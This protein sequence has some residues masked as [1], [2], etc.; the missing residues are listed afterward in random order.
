MPKSRRNKSRTTR[1]TRKLLRGWPLPQHAADESKEGRGRV[2]VIG[3]E[4]TLPGAVV[5]A[6]IAA[7]RAGAGK[8]QIATCRS[9]APHVGI[10]V[11]ECLAFGLDETP[12]GLISPDAV[13]SLS[14]FMNETD[15]VLIGPGMKGHSDEKHFVRNLLK[16][17]NG[18]ATLVID[19]GALDPRN[20]FHGDAILT[21]H[22][23]EMSKM[24]RLPLQEVVKHPEETSIEAARFFN[25]V[26]ALKGSVT[27]IASPKGELFRYDSGD[28]GLATSGSGDT[29]AG[30]IT[31][32]VARGASPL[33][34][35]LWGVFLH[36]AA[37]NV[38]AKRIGRVGY[39]ARELLDEIPP[40]MNRA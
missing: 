21:P 24:L 17:R 22:A 28:V 34:A 39:L 18:D 40:I 23:G 26:V 27:F 11:P 33:H 4:I 36:G 16:K 25:A 15:A 5:L 6:G 13:S 30:V 14:D 29:L 9:I 19:A 2:L 3:G 31:G 12:D 37:G 8:L 20:T 1:V 32:L 35:T 7:L 38:L 10:A